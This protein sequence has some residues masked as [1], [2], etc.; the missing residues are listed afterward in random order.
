[1]AL[2]QMLLNSH[3]VAVAFM[4]LLISTP[5]S[6]KAIMRPL[7]VVRFLAPIDEA[8][9]MFPQNVWGVTVLWKITLSAVMKKLFEQP[10][11]VTLMYTIPVVLSTVY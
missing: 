4:V 11:T 9:R 2:G 6:P 5:P 8:L 7:N 1:M 10:V 3:G